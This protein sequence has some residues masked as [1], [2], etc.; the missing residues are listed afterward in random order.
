M[1]KKVRSYF[2]IVNF[3]TKEFTID[4]QEVETFKIT[5]SDGVEFKEVNTAQKIQLGL[6]LLKG[7]MKAKEIYTPVIIDGVEVLTSDLKNDASQLIITRAIKGINKLE[8]K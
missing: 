1:Q 5:N 8:V 7:I 4:G 2:E 6:D 3:R